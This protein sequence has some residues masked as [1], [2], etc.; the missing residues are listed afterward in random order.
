LPV[1]P[2]PPAGGGAGAPASNVTLYTSGGNEITAENY[3]GSNYALDIN[4]TNDTVVVATG[5]GVPS[6]I[7]PVGGSD[8]SN[9]RI[10]NLTS[11]GEVIVSVTDMAGGD[12]MTYG[13]ATLTTSAAS[14]IAANAARRG[15]QIQN[16]DASKPCYWGSNS[17]VTVNN[18][19]E[20]LPGSVQSQSGLGTYTGEI[21]IITSTGGTP[22]TNGIRYLEIDKA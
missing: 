22:T 20:I 16:L 15:F 13:S 12:T 2:Y 7:V 3:S 18:G 14:L 8:G 11:S 9:A 19:T 1:T 6:N 21:F 10:M 4:V 17:S 5:S